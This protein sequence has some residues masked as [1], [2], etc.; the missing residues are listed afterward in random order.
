MKQYN[1]LIQA[2]FRRSGEQ[3]YRPQCRQCRACQSI[4]VLVDD[5]QPSKSQKR[6]LNKN[7]D[8]TRGLIHNK[9]D[10][11]PILSLLIFV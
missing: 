4:R 6:V 7:N 10:L 9:V 5:F 2:G 1:V 3:V 11:I 8:F